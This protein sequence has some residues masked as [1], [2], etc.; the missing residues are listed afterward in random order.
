[1]RKL[2]KRDVTVYSVIVVVVEE[3]FFNPQMSSAESKCQILF[4]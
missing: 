3:N 1:M 2:Q 4:L